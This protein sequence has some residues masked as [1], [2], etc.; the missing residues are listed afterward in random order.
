MAD[1]GSLIPG[2]AEKWENISD[3]EFK[4]YLRKGVKFHNGETLTAEDVKFTLD[5]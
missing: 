1:D 5:H 3:T 2:L 4:F